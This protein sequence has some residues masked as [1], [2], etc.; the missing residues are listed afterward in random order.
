MLAA[1]QRLHPPIPPPFSTFLARQLFVIQPLC[2]LLKS[3]HIIGSGAISNLNS[4][5]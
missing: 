1:L 4:I 2:L 3:T 5:H